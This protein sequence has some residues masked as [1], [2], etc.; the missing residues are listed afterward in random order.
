MAG[1]EKKMDA[2]L[3][4]SSSA[5]SPT[6]LKKHG[7]SGP[8]PEKPSSDTMWICTQCNCPHNNVRKLVCRWCNHKRSSPVQSNVSNASAPLAAEQVRSTADAA[9]VVLPKLTPGPIEKPWMKKILGASSM[10]SSPQHA[11]SAFASPVARSD[12]QPVAGVT[13]ASANKRAHLQQLLE[14]A[15]AGCLSEDLIKNIQRELEALPTPQVGGQLQEAGRLYQEKAKQERHHASQLLALDAQ[16]ENIAKQRL[17][18]DE[19]EQQLQQQRKQA[20]LNTSKTWS[21]SM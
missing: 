7:N 9:P 6:A 12:T 2:L 13:D 17:K 4:S 20:E 18:L 8:C 10:A 19:L 3:R 1:L 5:S 15:K 11:D 14:S 16:F 21:S